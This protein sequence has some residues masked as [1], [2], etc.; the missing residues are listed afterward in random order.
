MRYRGFTLV[1]LLVVVSVIALLAGMLLPALSIVRSSAQSTQCMNSLRQLGI[2]FENYCASNG[3]IYPPAN[4]PDASQPYG[5]VHWYFFIAPYLESKEAYD[6]GWGNAANWVGGKAWRC[7]NRN[8]PNFV[9]QDYGTSFGYNSVITSAEGAFWTWEGVR[10]GAFS[11]SRMVLLADRWAQNGTAAWSLDSNY[12]VSPNYIRAA[13]VPGSASDGTTPFA[14]RLSHRKKANH[15]FLD[16]HVQLLSETQ[17]INPGTTSGNQ[18]L[19]PNIW[20]GL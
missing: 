20:R 4:A 3:S 7:P 5:Y 11:A 2:G 8:L 15:L 18:T 1:E 13:L 9:E 16:G 10:A 6:G 17:E 14:L 12:G 19:V